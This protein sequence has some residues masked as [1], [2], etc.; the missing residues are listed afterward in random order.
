M[1]SAN[2]KLEDKNL[3]HS[4]CLCGWNQLNKSYSLVNSEYYKNHSLVVNIK[5]I[6]VSIR[7]RDA[8]KQYS[9]DPAKPVAITKKRNCFW[10]C[11]GYG[12]HFHSAKWV[13]QPFQLFDRQKTPPATLFVPVMSVT[14]TVMLDTCSS[15]RVSVCVCVSVCVWFNLEVQYLWHTSMNL[16]SSRKN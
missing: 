4:I 9:A 8:G 12:D 16:K 10:W 13:I 3:Q 1:S 15:A 5:G 11:W 6:G 2:V 14:E 7:A